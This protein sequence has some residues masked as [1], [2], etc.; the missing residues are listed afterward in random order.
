MR[1]ALPNTK[2]ALHF[3]RPF[4]LALYV[5]AKIAKIAKTDPS[6]TLGSNKSSNAI[7]PMYLGSYQ[8]D[9]ACRLG[10]YYKLCIP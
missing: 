10:H 5:F 6:S 3:C 2:H 4:S 7:I 9:V 1:V 8:V